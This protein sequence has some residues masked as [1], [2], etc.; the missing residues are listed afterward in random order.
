MPVGNILPAEGRIY[1]DPR[2][3]RAVRQITAAPAIHHH[4]FFYIP[5]YDDS[6]QRLYFISHRTGSPQV[7]FEDGQG[8]PLIQLTDRPDLD[9]WSLHPSH[10]GRYVY[11]TAGGC[12]YRVE[13]EGFREDLVADLGAPRSNEIGAVG[14]GMG[15]T[16]VS[17]DDR[18][19]ATTIQLAHD[20]CEL[21]VVDLS[22]GQWTTVAQHNMI[23]HPQFHPD[24][25]EWLRFAGLY[26]DRLW[27]VRRD[28]SERR[29][30]YQ[31][32]ASRKEWI[33]H[34]TWIPGR[35]EIAVTNWPLGVMAVDVDAGDVRWIIRT[36]AWHPMVSP[37]GARIVADT[38][39]PDVGLIL[40]DVDGVDRPPTTLCYPES[41]N[42]GD[43]WQ[44][45][46]CPYDDG[47]VNV[48]APQHTHP[49]P[50][51]SPDGKRVVFTSDR[52][53]FAQVYEVGW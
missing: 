52:D 34:E 14:T 8:G 43:H 24:D 40:F 46:H 6:G 13:T 38:T 17:R 18:W 29:L 35:R 41:S 51:F 10:D 22:D 44:A 5:A 16:A 1:Q 26:T 19:W 3:G 53:G 23:A 27:I 39:N 49:H 30:I 12:G 45:R 50:S 21:R 2:T 28:G 37:D 47:P 9:E 4:P 7:Y 20:Q 33:V 36:S 25:A 31:R 48:Y 11:F 42:R 15:T 32:D